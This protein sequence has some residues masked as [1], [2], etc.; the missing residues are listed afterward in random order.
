MRKMIIIW[1]LTGIVLIVL[2]G[3]ASHFL[4]EWTNY[5]R[6]AALIA[7]VN[8]S[9]WEHLKLAFWPGLVFALVEYPFIRKSVNNF[10]VAKTLGLL[11]MP[12][13]VAVLFYGYTA[14]FGR[15]YLLIDILTFVLA[16]VVGQL[17]SYRTLITAKMRLSAQRYALVGL[18]IMIAAF[19]LLS[20]YPPRFFLFQDPGTNEYGILDSYDR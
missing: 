16:V 9:T 15:N 12:V 6:P 8:E 19:S 1:E 13:V 18:A 10:W 20:Y 2:V 11:A 4:F 3:S 7:A 14:L 5:W 17:A